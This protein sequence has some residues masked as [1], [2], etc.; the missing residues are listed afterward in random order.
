[1]ELGPPDTG[2][3]AG[4]DTTIVTCIE[5]GGLEDQVVL[6]ARSL[7]RLGGRHA[8]TPVV[9]VK[10]R[11]GPPLRRS[12]RRALGDLDVRIVDEPVNSDTAWWAHA[13]KPAALSWADRE[14][15]T[16]WISWMDSDMFVLRE[17]DALAPPPGCDFIARAGEAFDVASSG[18]DDK[19]PFWRAVCEPQ[20]L[21]FD[22]FPTITS[23]PDD[24]PIKAYWQAGLFTFRRGTAFAPTYRRVMDDLL[25]GSIGSRFAGIYHTDQVALAIAVQAAR[26]SVAQ[27]A[28]PMNLNLNDKDP[29]TFG[30]YP[31]DAV[32][33]V[34]YH[35]SFWADKADW[36][37][38]RLA[39]MTDEQRAVLAGL[40]PLSAGTVTSRLHRRL[41]EIARS[42]P[43]KAYVAR[44]RLM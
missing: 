44:A 17:P 16:Q 5:A 22:A 13:N 35:G 38:A 7:R 41:Y 34:H 37:I 42:R 4:D 18:H 9:A 40:V 29:E 26:M 10:A 33:I 12:I 31:L 23:F 30:R 1:M 28:P 8:G 19:A 36:A 25:A 27:Y 43:L 21:D 2:A 15:R 32:K 20:G 24:R 39:G 14:L 6:L 11:R 3:T